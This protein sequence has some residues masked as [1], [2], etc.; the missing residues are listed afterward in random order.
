MIMSEFMQNVGDKGQ[1]VGDT[2]SLKFHF[3]VEATKQVGY[4]G[5]RVWTS[6]KRWN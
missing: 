6:R 3:G 5:A 4:G 1:V 2:L